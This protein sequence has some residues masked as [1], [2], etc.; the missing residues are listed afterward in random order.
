MF[1]KLTQQIYVLMTPFFFSMDYSMGDTAISTWLLDFGD[2]LSSNSS[3]NSIYHQY[4]S[5]DVNNEFIATYTITDDNGCID[6][7][8]YRNRS[9]LPT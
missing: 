9:V 6:V 2:G 1:L 3:G 7:D 4:D 5:C 8:L